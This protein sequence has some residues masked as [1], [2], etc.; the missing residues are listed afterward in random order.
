MM[1]IVCPHLSKQYLF[2][3]S[4]TVGGTVISWYA[5]NLTPFHCSGQ[6]LKHWIET[7]ITTSMDQSSAELSSCTQDMEGGCR[8]KSI[9]I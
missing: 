6:R 5:S 7:I 2:L 9:T 1:V 4:Y 8:W 3:L